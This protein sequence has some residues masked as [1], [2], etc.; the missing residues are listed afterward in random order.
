MSH[1]YSRIIMLETIA[2]VPGMVAAMVRHFNSLRRMTRD[3]GWIHTLLGIV[4]NKCIKYICKYNKVL[5]LKHAVTGRC[6]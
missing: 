4:L 6:I 1:V 3:H 2:G 5:H